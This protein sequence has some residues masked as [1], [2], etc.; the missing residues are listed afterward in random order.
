MRPFI[1][2]L[3]FATLVTACVGTDV[4][5]IELKDVRLEITDFPSQLQVNDSYQLQALRFDS[6]GAP[7]I[8]Q[9]EWSVSDESVAAISA[10]GIMTG[11]AEGNVMV[12]ATYQALSAEV[13]VEISME[14]TMGNGTERTGSLMGR[15]G[16]DISGGFRIFVDETTGH[17]MLEFINA[18]IDNSAPGPYYYLSN[19][20]NNVSGGI[21]LGPAPDGNKSYDLGEE[22]TISSYSTVVVWCEPFGVTLGYGQFEN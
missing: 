17:T 7:M 4:L 20:T 2:L 13:T 8:I 12:I 6:V 9:P 15:G 3:L 21:N 22:V 1:V 10:D 5:E 18:E 16:Y 14:E 19:S 11:I